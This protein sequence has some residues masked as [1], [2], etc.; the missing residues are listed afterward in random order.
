[1]DTN[2]FLGSFAQE[3]VA[4]TTRVIKTAIVGDNYWKVVIFVEGDR[5]V[6]SSTALWEKI[7]GSGVPQEDG[8]TSREYKAL[9]VSANDYA[10]YTTGLLRSWLNDLFCNGFTG[11]CIL[12]AVS[13]KDETETIT[14]EPENEGDPT[15]KTLDAKEVFLKYLSDAYALMKA[16]AYHKTVCALPGVTVDDTHP[17]VLD[18]DVALEFAKLCQ[19]DH[20]LLSSAPYYPFS[21]TTPSN[22]T[23]DKIYTALN[24]AKVPAFLSAC[25][26]ATRNAALY[27]LGL[28]LVEIN[29]SGTCVGNSMDMIK[30]TNITCSGP[31][32]TNLPKSTRSIL[33]N[34]HIQAFKPVGNNTG[35]VAALGAETIVTGDVVQAD[36]II[37]Y[38]TYMTK[39]RVAEM[40]TTDNYIR[41]AANY[42]NIVTAMSS[43]LALF[44]SSGSGRLRD[45]AISA[46]AFNKLPASDEDIIIIP[47]AW[48]ATY[49]DQVREVQITGALYI[50]V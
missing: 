16:Y 35:A 42:S 1:M 29:G 45:L 11:N 25:Q 46:P 9:S 17:E 44:G 33:E 47:D 4:F 50:G 21:T 34:I 31:E 2:D 49:T 15:T 8:T 32:G 3:N 24:G 43:K 19:A 5:F 23:T 38:I 37:A 41:N 36:W 30:S 12:V 13:G 39:V 20:K 22:P 26:D 48:S 27:S 6:D 18:A 28:A 40:I 10:E 7:P 14:V